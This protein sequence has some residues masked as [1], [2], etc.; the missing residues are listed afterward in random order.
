MGEPGALSAPGEEGRGFGSSGGRPGGWQGASACGEGFS[1]ASI[2]R[3]AAERVRQWTGDDFWPLSVRLPATRSDTTTRTGSDRML[4]A[5]RTSRVGQ[6]VLGPPTRSAEAEPLLSTP[7]AGKPKRTPL[8]VSPSQPDL[9]AQT[10]IEG[11]KG[12]LRDT[13]LALAPPRGL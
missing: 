8:P 10:C 1:R 13:R 3:A 7:S 11:E 2:G 12:T 4:S 9:P 5:M 6:A